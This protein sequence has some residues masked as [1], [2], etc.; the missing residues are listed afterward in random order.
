MNKHRLGIVVGYG[1]SFFDE[2]FT[3]VGRLHEQLDVVDVIALAL[4]RERA[5]LVEHELGKRGDGLRRPFVTRIDRFNLTQR[6]VNGKA[7][8]RFVVVL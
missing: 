5:G 7:T 1:I 3:H 2:L 8:D 4:D 6:T